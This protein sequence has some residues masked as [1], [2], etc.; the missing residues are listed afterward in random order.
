MRALPAAAGTRAE[1]VPTSSRIQLNALQSLAAGVAELDSNPARHAGHPW[2]G[3]GDLTVRTPRLHQPHAAAPSLE[4]VARLAVEDMLPCTSRLIP[5]EDQRTRL[6]ADVRWRSGDDAGRVRRSSSS[7]SSKVRSVRMAH[8]AI[9]G[10]TAHAWSELHSG[11]WEPRCPQFP[12]LFPEPS[13]NK[14]MAWT[15]ASLGS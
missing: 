5:Y 15:P 12:R 4:E 14:T 7:S 2:S 9:V 11:L 1:P 6:L 10:R 3:P 13:A 8:L